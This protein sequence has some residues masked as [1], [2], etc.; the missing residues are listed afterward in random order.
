M[1]KNIVAAT[2]MTLFIGSVSDLSAQ[3][4]NKKPVFLDD[5]EV[6]FESSPVQSVAVNK[7]PKTKKEIL[8]P[9]FTDRSA[10]FPDEAGT[11]EKATSIQ[12]KYALLL[13]TDVEQ[14]DNQPLFTL[15]DEWFG[16][17]YRY[18]G[19]TKS[20]IDC[21][22]FTQALYARVYGINLPRTAREQYKIAQPISRAEL[23]EGD[24]LFFN[25]TGSTSHVGYYLQN[26]KFVHAAS[27]GGVMISDLSDDYWVSRFAGVGRVQGVNTSAV[28]SQP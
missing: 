7:I 13:D 19:S 15:I 20:G 5:I 2:L 16:T 21:S 14:V 18:G 25:T 11:I 4:R 8:A 6:G 12:L 28:F 22:A 24:L 17:P 26:N 3:K 10:F 27:S 23:K 9:V 1:V